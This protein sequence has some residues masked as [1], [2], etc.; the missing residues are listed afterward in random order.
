VFLK[1]FSCR[2]EIFSFIDLKKNHTEQ[3]T[4]ASAEFQPSWSK[5]GQPSYEPFQVTVT[6]RSQDGGA[7]QT[8]LGIGVAVIVEKK[9]PGALDLPAAGALPFAFVR[10]DDAK[11]TFDAQPRKE[12]VVI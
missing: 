6:L 2:L 9:T 7:N 5:P 11:L 3:R 1:H 10:L 8:D 12:D 4:Y